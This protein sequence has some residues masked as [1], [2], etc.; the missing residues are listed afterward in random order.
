MII[1]STKIHHS[2]HSTDAGMARRLEEFIR[3]AELKQ[4]VDTIA[5]IQRQKQFRTLAV[6]SFFSGEGKTLFCAAMALA[7]AETYQTRV[8]AVDTTTYQNKNSLVLKNCLDTS[9]SLID[10]MSLAEH[11]KGSSGL[12]TVAM[13]LQRAG[14]PD[15]DP[16]GVKGVNG[17]ALMPWINRE[18]DQALIRGLMECGTQQY[19]LILLDTAPLTAKNKSN[20]DPLLVARMSDAAVLV[21]S[22]QLLNVT[23]GDTYLKL[24]RDPSLHL[25]GMVSNEEF[26]L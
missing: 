26:S 13:D 3:Y 2:L 18:S 1:G 22:R 5:A 10:F 17:S 7:Y 8:L 14:E 16:E 24:L 11:Q 21:A 4:L 20:I 12:E 25:I 19:G 15:F 9:S 23:N 6:L